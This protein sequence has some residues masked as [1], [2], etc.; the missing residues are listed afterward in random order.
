M[1]PHI[2]TVLDVM[3]ITTISSINPVEFGVTKE[4]S[5]LYSVTGMAPGGG[6]GGPTG[7]K[8]YAFYM[9]NF[10]RRVSFCAREYYVPL[11]ITRQTP[12]PKFSGAVPGEFI[13]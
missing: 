4:L 2:W 3:V 10:L 6:I 12:P 7:M 8:I 11:M 5:V 9:V 1:T 13:S